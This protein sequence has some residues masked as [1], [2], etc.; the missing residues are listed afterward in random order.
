MQPEFVAKGPWWVQGVWTLGPVTIGFFLFLFINV[1]WLPSPVLTR[2][3][4]LTKATIENERSS[5]ETIKE[6]Q[7]L[8]SETQ[9]LLVQLQTSIAAQNTLRDARQDILAKGIRQICRNTARNQAANEKC[10]DL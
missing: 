9:K 3:D 6:G 1:G 4:D 5:T 7:R 8:I 2:L 10:D